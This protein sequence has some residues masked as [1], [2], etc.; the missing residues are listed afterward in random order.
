MVVE[1]PSD[2]VVRF[3]V[4]TDNGYC[5]RFALLASSKQTVCEIRFGC[6]CVSTRIDYVP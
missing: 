5:S 6:V 4:R 3:F 2:E 1:F